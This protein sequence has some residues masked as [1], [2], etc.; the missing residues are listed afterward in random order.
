MGWRD[1]LGVARSTPVSYPQY[2]HN[3][4]KFEGVGIIAYIAYIAD[5]TPSESGGMPQAPDDQVQ[6]DVFEERAAIREHDA[7]FPRVWAEGLARLDIARAPADVPPSRWVQFIDDAGRF[8]REWGAKAD[9]L[10]WGPLEIFGA[11]LR[12]PFARLDLAGL[13]WLLN[14]RPVLALTAET[15]IIDCGG[16]VTQTFRRRPATGGDVALPWTECAP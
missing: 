8:A 10:G 6:A 13:A 11:D 2:T 1:V 3:P 12:A 7:G 9:A 5:D 16:G 15:A 4:Q 14:R